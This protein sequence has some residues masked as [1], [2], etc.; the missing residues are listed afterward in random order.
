M[1]HIEVIELVGDQISSRVEELFD[2]E[3][4]D[5]WF[6]EPVQT[7]LTDIEAVFVAQ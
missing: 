6:L 5:T 7:E 3:L 1:N 4:E 2:F